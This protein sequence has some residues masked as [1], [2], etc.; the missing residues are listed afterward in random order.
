MLYR[1]I[2]PPKDGDEVQF[3]GVYVL[4]WNEVEGRIDQPTVAFVEA[5]DEEIRKEYKR[6]FRCPHYKPKEKKP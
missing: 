4:K 3:V 6:R 1:I 2:K 5:T